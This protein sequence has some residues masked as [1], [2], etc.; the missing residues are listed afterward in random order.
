MQQNGNI[1]ET[2]EVQIHELV[3]YMDEED[4]GVEHEELEF[5][6]ARVQTSKD[7]IQ[8]FSSTLLCKH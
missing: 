4:F 6:Y 5:N 3:D 8:E 1:T 2:G 7:L